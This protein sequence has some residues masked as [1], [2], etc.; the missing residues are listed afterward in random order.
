MSHRFKV[1]K[2]SLA[3]A[4][5]PQQKS[6]AFETRLTGG[7]TG[8]ERFKVIQQLAHLLML[9]AGMTEENDRER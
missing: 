1:R 8:Q 5:V 4:Q 6:I 9:A 7:L 3:R 2:N